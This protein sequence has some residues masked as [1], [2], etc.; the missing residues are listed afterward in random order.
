[1]HRSAAL[2]IPTTIWRSLETELLAERDRWF[3]WL[4]VLIGAGMVGYFALAVEPP[5][6]VG[7]AVLALAALALVVLY[8]R[9]GGRVGSIAGLATPPLRHF[10]SIAGSAKC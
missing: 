4:P 9:T 2:A 5:R 10:T 8:R 7:G 6:W 3:L 1:M